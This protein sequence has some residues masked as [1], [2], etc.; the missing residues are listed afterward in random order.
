[1]INATAMAAAISARPSFHR[2]AATP[3]SGSLGAA[4]AAF[5]APP[6]IE[7]T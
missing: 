5:P 1:M 4:G 2:D 7:L 3:G 6:A